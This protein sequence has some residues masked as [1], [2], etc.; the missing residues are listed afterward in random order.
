MELKKSILEPDRYEYLSKEDSELYDD[1]KDKF[2]Y[3]SKQIKRRIIE[4]A[5]ASYSEHCRSRY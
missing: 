3:Q 5:Q 4:K 1:V 2:D